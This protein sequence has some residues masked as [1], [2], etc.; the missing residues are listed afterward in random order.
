[1]AKLVSAR[2]LLPHL[3]VGEERLFEEANLSEGLFWSL[4]P[5]SF[6]LVVRTDLSGL[7]IRSE[8]CRD[9]G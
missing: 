6:P 3:F 2:N 5:E 4:D 7:E 1:M 9:F 8:T